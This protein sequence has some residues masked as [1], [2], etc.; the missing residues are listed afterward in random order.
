MIDKRVFVPPHRHSSTV[1]VP[2]PRFPPC[3]RPLAE[4]TFL[5]QLKQAL[6]VFRRQAC[7]TFLFISSQ[8]NQVSLETR[9]LCLYCP[10]YR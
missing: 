7:F 5:V 2:V 8:D 9:S 3:R 4:M 1:I 10:L 6:A